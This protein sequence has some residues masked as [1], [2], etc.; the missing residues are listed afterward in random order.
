MTL[1]G[2]AA[3]T[4][5][6]YHPFSTPTH[7][8]TH[9][10]VLLNRYA[11][12]H[13]ISLD[14]SSSLPVHSFHETLKHPCKNVNGTDQNLTTKATW[15]CVTLIYSLKDNQWEQR[16]WLKQP[17]GLTETNAIPR[18]TVRPFSCPLLRCHPNHQCAVTPRGLKDM[19]WEVFGHMSENSQHI[20][21]VHSYETVSV[22]L[23]P[24]GGFSPLLVII[25]KGP[26]FYLFFKSLSSQ[27]A[28]IVA[29][30]TLKDPRVVSDS[31][32]N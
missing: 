14:I 32:H 23:M 2:L 17:S 4:P 22:I 20:N 16:T 9:R 6:P 30:N 5:P 31:A 29:F 13:R 19:G 15:K 3:N 12:R 25:R 24:R 11:V 1:P 28:F 8:H 10:A 18:C 7:P 21:I 26:R 27:N